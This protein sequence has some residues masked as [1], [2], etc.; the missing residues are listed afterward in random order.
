MIRRELRRVKGEA[1]VWLCIDDAWRFL[2]RDTEHL[3]ILQWR[4]AA[5]NEDHG[6]KVLKPKHRYLVHGLKRIK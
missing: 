5:N 4:M 1:A 6:V 3:A 2:V